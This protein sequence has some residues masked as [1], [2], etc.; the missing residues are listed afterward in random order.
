MKSF[1]PVVSFTL[2]SFLAT[3]EGEMPENMNEEI[4]FVLSLVGTVTS[5]WYQA[6]HLLQKY[7]IYN[8]NYHS[9]YFIFVRA[10][11]FILALTPL[12]RNNCFIQS[13]LL[14]LHTLIKEYYGR[15]FNPIFLQFDQTIAISSSKEHLLHALMIIYNSWLHT[16]TTKHALPGQ[17]DA[18]CVIMC[19]TQDSSINSWFCQLFG[20]ILDFQNFLWLEC[21]QLCEAAFW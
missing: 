1:I 21:N 19:G 7:E 20:C 11:K 15:F 16:G 10:R 12:R 9:I 2:E 5:M 3:Y 8:C 14:A 18:V 4:Q 17:L 13:L 6:R